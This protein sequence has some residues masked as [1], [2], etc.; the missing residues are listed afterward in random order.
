MQ[1]KESLLE[2]FYRTGVFPHARHAAS[3]S[4]SSGGNSGGS[5]SP[6]VLNHSPAY[7]LALHAFFLVANLAVFW[8]GSVLYGLLLAPRISS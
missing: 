6:T 7:Y 2:E 4:G 5:R 1:E 3:S 8:A